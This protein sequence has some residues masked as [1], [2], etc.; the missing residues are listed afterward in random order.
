MRVLYFKR[1]KYNAK[2]YFNIIFT[3][4]TKGGFVLLNKN[5]VAIYVRLS[6]EDLESYEKES[7]S[8][9]NQKSMLINYAVN[10]HWQIFN[11]Y[12]DEDYSGAYSG[13][14]NS[15][16]EFNKMIEDAENGKFSIILCKTQ[17]RF[18][19]NMEVIEQFIHG[20][21]IE[22]GIRFISIVDNADTNVKGNKKARQIN[23][24]INEWYL[25]DL[26]ENIKSVFKDKMK[27]GEFLA[28][29][30]PYGYS[31]DKN[32]KNHLVLHP[33]TS[34]IV[35]QI[36]EWHMEGYGAA[37]ICQMLNN[38]GIPNPRKQQE[39]DGLRKTFMY[40]ATDMGTWTTTSVGDIL[41][42][43]VYV[44]DVVQH[45]KEK[46]SYKSKVI[47]NVPKHELIIVP[48]MHEPIITREVFE[49]TQKNLS[50]K[51]RASGNGKPHILSG[52]V[53]CHYCG[54]LMQKNH[55]VSSQAGHIGYLR[56]RD[57]Y[58]YSSEKKCPTPNIRIDR[59]LEAIQM[60]LINKFKK[61]FSDECDKDKISRLLNKNIRQQEALTR[62]VNSLKEKQKQLRQAQKT[63]YFDKVNAVITVEQYIEYNNDLV[64]QINKID[65]DIAQIED[66][67]SKTAVV[68]KDAFDTH[69]QILRFFDE[70]NLD[71][72]IIDA[73]I[74]RIEFGEK[75]EETGEFLLKIFWAWD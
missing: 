4:D 26:S 57:K 3:K 31:K 15:R 19:R 36:F 55:G 68:G 7:E 24:L 34:L 49:Q 35:R 30:P 66:E 44:G 60:E 58:A 63:L 25:E 40:N 33:T 71:K 37:K 16:P 59:I 74:D 42:N 1:N 50:Y 56:C 52:K 51:R 21:F 45:T 53:F 61:E 9:Q 14:E 12:C 29:F 70:C 73:V 43:Q 6:K 41:H 11:I 38:R 72:E 67:I 62:Q 64:T 27:R 13:E 8:I 54:K 17:S 69:N 47:K 32:N 23:S 39:L 46:V 5:V 75:D 28:S 2:F 65:F 22:W 20:K 18:S 10:Q 48:N